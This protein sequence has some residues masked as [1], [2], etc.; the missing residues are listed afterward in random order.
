MTVISDRAVAT[1]GERRTAA[2]SALCSAALSRPPTQPSGMPP[3]ETTA[4]CASARSP[5]GVTNTALATAGSPE[6]A[7][8][9]VARVHS[10]MT[11]KA[12]GSANFVRIDASAVAGDGRIRG[13]VAKRT[14]FSLPTSGEACTGG[15]RGYRILGVQ[16]VREE[17]R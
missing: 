17:R 10:V 8:G 5:A 15:A 14:R 1:A 7:T 13:T 3:A 16:R 2:S 6:R 4:R 12:H 11:A 9:A